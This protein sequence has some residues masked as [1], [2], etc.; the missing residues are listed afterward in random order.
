VIASIQCEA[1]PGGRVRVTNVGE[2]RLELRRTALDASEPIEPGGDA[3]ISNASDAVSVAGVATVA[4]R[5]ALDGLHRW[6]H[7]PGGDGDL[8]DAAQAFHDEV[9]ALEGPATC[10]R[11]EAEEQA[12]WSRHRVATRSTLGRVGAAL[13][14]CDGLEPQLSDPFHCAV[15]RIRAA[16]A[17]FDD[18]PAT[19]PAGDENELAGAVV[20]AAELLDRLVLAGESP[21]SDPQAPL[22]I[23][24]WLARP[25]VVRARASAPKRAGVAL[26]ELVAL[27]PPP[28]SHPPPDPLPR[29]F[30]DAVVK[31]PRTIEGDAA[32]GAQFLLQALR[33]AQMA[34]H[35]R[36]Y[37][38]EAIAE[39]ARR[40]A[41]LDEPDRSAWLTGYR[42][43]VPDGL[44]D[45]PAYA[46]RVAF[47]VTDAHRDYYR[48]RLVYAAPEMM[49][50]FDR[51]IVAAVEA[52]EKAKETT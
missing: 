48:R 24:A 47:E 9:E 31:H 51:E 7:S 46:A 43:V 23:D 10:A 42:I 30:V 34:W 27:P 36:Q 26:G 17:G 13:A 39:M 25:E 21:V 41:P 33:G 18:E 44:D 50:A 37:H 5:Q 22:M 38:P 11:L 4:G 20:A 8:T 32:T 16:L 29:A 3:I 2:T 28:H 1:L 40:A 35:A 15:R 12:E 49:T 14:V 52:E 19:S 6:L 45:S